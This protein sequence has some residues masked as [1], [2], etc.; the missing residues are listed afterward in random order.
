MKIII[1]LSIAILGACGL[2]KLTPSNSEGKTFKAKKLEFMGELNPIPKDNLAT[3][4]KSAI[5]EGN[6]LLLEVNYV[7]GCNEHT[8]KLVG[9]TSIS[10]SLPPRRGIFLVNQSAVED[11]CKANVTRKLKI[12]IKEF[13]YKQEVGSEIW[14]DLEGYKEGLKYSVTV[15]K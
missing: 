3:T 2:R 1:I 4:I 15:E 12:N 14:L 9:N 8:F 13:A 10:K 5:I 7:G 11:N 6:Y